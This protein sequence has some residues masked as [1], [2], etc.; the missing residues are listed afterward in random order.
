MMVN[1]MIG[2]LRI[3]PIDG[4]YSRHE[5]YM[6]GAEIKNV[7]MIDFHVEPAS[8]PSAE[9]EVNGQLDFNGLADVGLRLNPLSVREC[10]RGILFE[11]KINDDFRKGFLASIQSA[12][13]DADNYT[14]NEKLAEEILERLIGDDE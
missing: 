2:S 8:I 6:N 3:K 13:D 12:L 4:S 9:I 14:K 10:I 5:V 7:H 1:D 11:L